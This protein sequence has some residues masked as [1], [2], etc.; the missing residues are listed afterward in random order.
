MNR[1]DLR[2]FNWDKDFKAETG[3]M[4]PVPVVAAPVTETSKEISGR[5]GKQGAASRIGS[6]E[7]RK[8]Q[9]Q[10][11][12]TH[13]WLYASEVSVRKRAAMDTLGD[14]IPLSKRH[15]EQLKIAREEEEQ[16]QAEVRILRLLVRAARKAR[17]RIVSDMRCKQI[18]LCQMHQMWQDLEIRA[19]VALL[20]RDKRMDWTGTSQ[21]EIRDKMESTWQKYR[22]QVLVYLSMDNAA[23]CF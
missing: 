7:Q 20:T 10:R 6:G 11:K 12:E 18:E 8:Q 4:N 16:V 21:K 23:R 15:E 5:M 22:Q 2:L 13:C 19:F 17:D 3:T 1:A 14:C 9:D